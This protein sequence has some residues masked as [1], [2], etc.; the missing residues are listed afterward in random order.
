MR[1]RWFILGIAISLL[2]ACNDD[3]DDEANP[4]PDVGKDVQIFGPGGEDGGTGGGGGSA[5]GGGGGEQH[6]R[7]SYLKT[8]TPRGGSRSIDLFIYDFEDNEEFSLTAGVAEIDCASRSC[9][10]NRDMHWLGW[11]Q[12]LE[13]GS[14]DL[15]VAPID[16]LHKRVKIGDKRRV[17]SGVMEFHF[18]GEQLVYS[19]TGEGEEISVLIEPIEG[20]DAEACVEPEDLLQC[21]QVVGS[22]NAGGSFRITE[23]GGLIILI[24]TTL[25]NMS[26]SFFNANN[27]QSVSFANFGEE[28][29]TGSEFSGRLPMG[30]SPDSRYMV[31]FTREGFLWK[32]HVA[33]AIPGAPPPQRMELFETG[34]SPTGD[35]DRE[36]PF[37]FNE[38]R[39]DPLFSRDS[40]QF[41]FQAHGDCA[42]RPSNDNPTNRDDYDIFRLP[43]DLSAEPENVTE[44]VRVSHWSNH[45]IGDFALSPTEEHLAFSASRPNNNM[46]RSIWLINPDSKEY[47][48]D[49]Q[50]QPIPS[51]D[52][53]RRCEFIYDDTDGADISYRELRFYEVQF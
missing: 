36:M 20:F 3:D 11:Q 35:C 15:W 24:K 50:T 31:V 16:L 52:G 6:L 7:L 10:L 40:S 18:S 41:Y 19:Q 23:E 5:G 45:D 26:L 46:S 29:G 37:N 28:E 49:R 12:P 33:D 48:C 30:L 51:L 9:K 34:S 39:F 21:R 14:Y 1:N 27:G 17:A 4:T 22:I 2:S 42:R 44:N 47:N 13:G 8:T 38:V 32:V 25:S 43:K 53:R